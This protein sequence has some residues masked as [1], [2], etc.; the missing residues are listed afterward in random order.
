MDEILIGEKK[1]ISSKQAAKTTGYAKDY[2][3]QLCREGRVPARLVGRS[4][5]VLEAAIHDHRFG[6]DRNVEKENAPVPSVFPRTWEPP[7]YE[8]S[9]VELLP[10]VKRPEVTE[11]PEPISPNEEIEQVQPL[12]DSWEAWF[13]H[14]EAE[15]PVV[16][17]LQEQREGI[18]EPAVVDEEQKPEEKEENVPI[19]AIYHPEYQPLP[20]E[21]LQRRNTEARLP[22]IE[23][24]EAGHEEKKSR[25]NKVLVAAQLA[26]ALIAL[27][28]MGSAVFSSGY[29]DTYVTS[30]GVTRMMAGVGVYN[31]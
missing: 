23:E 7:R 13:D 8:S 24:K 1:Y 9:P 3:G 29:F 5:Y 19:H 15:Q 18:E 2:I 26:G 31:R 16:S 25:Q 4:W 22:R 27:F 14:A 21:I 6:E 20:E 11:T 10:D 28:M 12:Q 17:T 30:N